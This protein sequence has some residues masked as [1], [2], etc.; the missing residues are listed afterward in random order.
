MKIKRFFE[1][2]VQGPNGTVDL[3]NDISTSRV[4]EIIKEMSSSI[5]NFDKNHTQ[6]KKFEEELKKYT[7]KSSSKND[8]ID[9]SIIELQMVNKSL[10]QDIL[11][12]MD[13]I[14][15][16]LENYIKE[17]RNYIYTK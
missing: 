4:E 6:L 7:N 16:K 3:S 2:E 14:I 11:S 15:E 10:E 9:D 5:D 8:Q 17:G 13:I 12:R 1:N